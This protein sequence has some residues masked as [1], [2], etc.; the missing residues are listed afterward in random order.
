MDVNMAAELSPT[1]SS[2]S[3]E[4][5]VSP[6]P[7]RET[8]AFLGKVT[9]IDYFTFQ[10]KHLKV[11][12]IDDMTETLYVKL[13]ENMTRCDHL[14]ITCEYLL[15]RGSYGAVYAHADNATVKLYD[16]VT[17]LYHEL[18]VCDM[19]QI[20]KATAEDGQDKALVDY[21]SAC[22]SCHALFMPQFRCSLQDYGHWHDGSIE[23]LVRGF[24]GL[25]DAVYFLNRHCGLFHSDISPSNI[26][27]DFTD[28]M[29]GMGR[30]VLTDYG[31]A[32][33]HDRNKMLDVRLKSSKGRQLYRLYCQREPFSIAKDT[34][35]P[36]CLLSKCYILR[37]AGTSLTPRRVAPW[38][39]RRPFAWICSRSATRCSMVSCTSLTPPTKSPTPTL[40]W[41]LT[42][43]TRSTFCNLQPQRW[44][45][46]RCCRRCGT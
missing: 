32:S 34:Y 40:T 35:K 33:L 41:D 9:V 28:T 1:N 25:K 19:I 38:G 15:G 46:W 2:S 8:Q 29:W 45:C 11:T 24:Q 36:L 31:T 44:C 17:E 21:L 27:V 7:P 13:P 22:T 6:E 30:L 39:R 23:P 43:P 4:L 18:M 3:G 10:H 20:G 16:S 5:S 37:G 42:D 14:P 12:N 26:L